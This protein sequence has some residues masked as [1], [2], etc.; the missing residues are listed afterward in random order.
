MPCASKKRSSITQSAT[1]DIHDRF[2]YDNRGLLRYAL[3]N[4]L[5]P[6]EYVYDAAGN[7]L[8]TI[9]YGA[10]IGSTATYTL[11]YVSSQ[12]TT[13]NLGANVNN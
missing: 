5:R 3:D 8:N 12:I 2:F 6:T 9:G 1:R 13:L 10:S 11:A 4:N 7:L